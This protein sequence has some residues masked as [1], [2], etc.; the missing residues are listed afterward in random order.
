MF[1]CLGYAKIVAPYRK[2]LDD[3]S[4]ALVHLGTEPGTKAYRLFDPVSKKISVSRD[5]VFMEEES[6]RWNES[7]KETDKDI[8]SFSVKLG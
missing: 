8:D 6:W 3:R 7:K 4:R 5:V 1:G 2:E